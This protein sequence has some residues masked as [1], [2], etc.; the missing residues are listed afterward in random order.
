M[1]A[2]FPSLTDIKSGRVVRNAVM[3]A[4]ISFNNV[5]YKRA[6]V[7]LR[8]VGGADCLDGSKIK[9]LTPRWKGKR[10]D[11]VKKGGEQ[12]CKLDNW[13]VTNRELY[14][15][16]KGEIVARVLEVAV[17]SVMSMHVY[18]FKDKLFIQR[19]GDPIGMRSTASLA[20][21]YRLQG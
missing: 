7:Y 1:E 5:D 17:I 6:L 18:S 15:W 14:Q 13:K 10:S 21:K 12:S 9:K 2:L 4:K 8:L 19:S 3:G 20:D 11:L 16:E